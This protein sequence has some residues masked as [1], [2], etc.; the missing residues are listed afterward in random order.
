VSL[1][2]FRQKFGRP[3]FDYPT[4]VLW[5]IAILLGF[6]LLSNLGLL[7]D[8][9]IVRNGNRVGVD[10]KSYEQRWEPLRRFLPAQGVVGYLSRPDPAVL[11]DED[12]DGYD[13]AQKE[14]QLA[15]Y[16]LA[17]IILQ[18]ATRQA[19]RNVSYIIVDE[20]TGGAS[21]ADPDKLIGTP[22]GFR[23]V[24]DFGNGLLLYHAKLP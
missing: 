3:A 11:D 18:P 5:G 1:T 4:R 24:R 19:I 16:V 14:Y 22:E 6:A 8:A 20:Y 2:S 12:A 21:N 9:A 10:M 13:D 7:K 15:Q 17:P 23:L